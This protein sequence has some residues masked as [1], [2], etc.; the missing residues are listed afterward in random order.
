LTPAPVPEYSPGTMPLKDHILPDAVRPPTME[1]ILR[2]REMY[3]EGFTVSRILAHC[4]MS[5]G[6][7]YHWLDGGPPDADG[8]PMLDAIPRRR[9]VVGKRRAPLTADRVSLAGRLFRTAAR[10]ARDIELRLAQPSAA[11]PERE[12]DVRMLTMLVRAVRD[13]AGFESEAALKE[14]GGAAEPT[15]ADKIARERDLREAAEHIGFARH[16]LSYLRDA[17]KI[18]KAHSE[19]A[20]AAAQAQE[21]KAQEAARADEQRRELARRIEGMVAAHREQEAGGTGE[22]A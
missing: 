13:L 11:T 8:K 4:D 18:E 12:R 5:L 9:Q 10:Q 19:R 22:G 6:T 2:A 1:K 3:V 21:A 17:A 14:Q 16:M 15:L 7:L 20:A